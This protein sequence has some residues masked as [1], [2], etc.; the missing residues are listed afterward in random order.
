MSAITLLLLMLLIGFGAAGLGKGFRIYS[1]ASMGIFITFGILTSLETP[2][3]TTNMATPMIGVWERINI[4][5]YM[6]WMIVLAVLLMK[7]DRTNH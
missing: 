3:I 5:T 7:R 1:M 6:I 4:G 2:G